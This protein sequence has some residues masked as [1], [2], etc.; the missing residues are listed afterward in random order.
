MPTIQV[1]VKPGSK[2]SEF[3]ALEDGTYSARV[4]GQPVD[5]KANAELMALI[6][7]HFGCSKSAVSI[8]SG[9]RARVKLVQVLME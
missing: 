9:A 8:K 5:G 7:K 2:V 1:K 3:V 4:K 6:A